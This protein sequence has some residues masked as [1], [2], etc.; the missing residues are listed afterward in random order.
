MG[1]VEDGHILLT[2]GSYVWTGAG[3]LDAELRES[4]N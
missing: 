1:C 3:Q 4:P 2:S